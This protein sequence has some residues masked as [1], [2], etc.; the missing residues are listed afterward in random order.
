MMQKTLCALVLLSAGTTS[1]QFSGEFSGDNTAPTPLGTFAVGTTT[2]AGSVSNALGVVFPTP[3]PV[4]VDVFTFSIAD[5]ELLTDITLSG[6]TSTDDFG[7]VAIT[8]GGSFPFNAAELSQLA[9]DGLTDAGG[10]ITDFLGGALF[11]TAGPGGEII[12][13]VGADLAAASAGGS[14]FSFPLGA[15]QYTV[16]VQ[17]L[18]S[19]VLGYEFSFSVVPAPASAA[20]LGLSGLI[21]GRRRR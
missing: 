9:D 12:P 10:S 14:G 16:Y 21:A 6:F 5:G 4:D 20:L 8:A 2:V 13:D 7:F 15:G 17:Q 1:A 11:G 18:G 19:A 3:V